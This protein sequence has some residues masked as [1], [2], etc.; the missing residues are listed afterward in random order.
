MNISSAGSMRLLGVGLSGL[1]K[2]CAF[3]D[4]P[5]PIFHSFYDRIVNSIS[6]ATQAVS[7]VSK[8]KAAR[9][10]KRISLE[11]GM[12]N[13]IIVSSNGSWRKRVS[14]RYSA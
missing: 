6:I 8:Q 1:I 7:A 2:F 3:M 5:R 11:N 9:K 4:L 13:G 14:V 10:E 12:E